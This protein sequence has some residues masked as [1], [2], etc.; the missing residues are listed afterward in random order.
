[1]SIDGNYQSESNELNIPGTAIVPFSGGFS[2]RDEAPDANAAIVPGDEITVRSEVVPID[3]AGLS[4]S[5]LLPKLMKAAKEEFDSAFAAHKKCAVHVWNMGKYLTEAKAKRDGL[6]KKKGKDQPNWEV[7]LKEYGISV[8][9][10]NR[11]R[12]LYAN[13]PDQDAISDLSIMDAYEVAGIPDS[14]KKV[15]RIGKASLAK[16]AGDLAEAA[17]AE[18]KADDGGSNGGDNHGGG[19]IGIAGE[20]PSF[21]E[22]LRKF[23]TDFAPMNDANQA[24]E[25]SDEE[26]DEALTFV[27]RIAVAATDMIMRFEERQG[28]E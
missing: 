23:A 13:C 27:N 7:M 12:R 3:T 14:S 17:K 25:L 28:S 10:D 2:N 19:P 11:A 15:K 18:A 9:S 6:K 24:E 4:V 20:S 22:R 1:M 16:K 26:I 8:A 5:E 21:L